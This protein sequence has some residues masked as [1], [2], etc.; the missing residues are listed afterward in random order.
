MVRIQTIAK[1]EAE[2]KVTQQYAQKTLYTQLK[3][4]EKQPEKC[5]L[6]WLPC[7]LKK[8]KKRNYA[9]NKSA[10][11]NGKNLTSDSM[12]LKFESGKKLSPYV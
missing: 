8:F 2:N 11:I 10:W 3:N 5:D 12:W 6:L 7:I 4:N 1:L 9:S